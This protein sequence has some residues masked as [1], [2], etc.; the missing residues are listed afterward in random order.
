MNN[1]LSKILEFA[2]G[3][4]KSELMT[5]NQAIVSLIKSQQDVDF[6]KAAITFA[7]GDIVSFEDSSG[8]RVQGVVT[9]KNPSDNT[10]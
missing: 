5:L 1:K 9:K 6:K 3:L 8:I 7:K 4:T 2:D 10:R